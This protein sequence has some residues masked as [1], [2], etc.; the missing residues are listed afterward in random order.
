MA[1]EDLD[2]AASEQDE[3]AGDTTT[4]DEPAEE[5]HDTM[6]ETTTQT[7]TESPTQS[8]DEPGFP[9]SEASQEQVYPRTST[10]DELQDV[11]DFEVKRELRDR[12][13]KDVTGRELHDALLQV[14]MAHQDELVE[15]IV[16]E[17]I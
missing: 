2:D 3:Q 17:R 1:F 7:K 16:E 5:T 12:G 9:F 8:L 6:T 4:D 13:V 14:A 10:W 15:T 11:L